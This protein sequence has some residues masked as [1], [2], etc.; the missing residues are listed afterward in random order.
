M[1]NFTKVHGLQLAQNSYVKNFGVETVDVDPSISTTGKVWFNT[2]DKKFKCTTLDSD[3]STIIVKSFATLDE[4]SDAINNLNTAIEQSAISVADEGGVISSGVTKFNFVGANVQAMSDDGKEVTVYMPPP[5]FTSHWNTNDGTVATNVISD[6]STVSRLISSPTSEGT[7]FKIGN[8]TAGTAHSTVT[9]STLTYTSPSLIC[10][11]NLTSSF[12]ATIYDADGTTILAQNTVSTITGD[13]TTSVQGI[14]ITIGGWTTQYN[15][16]KASVSVVY[17]IATIL[18]SGG[19]FSIK[20]VHNSSVAY[21]KS[22]NDLFYD[23]STT[24]PS[25]TSISISPSA[26]NTTK[27]LSGV[28]YYDKTDTF[29]IGMAGINNINSLTYPSTFIQVES[30]NYYGI[31]DFGVTGADL[32][33]WTTAYNNTGA[34]YS[35]I[36]AISRS[37]F[38]AIA[39]TRIDAYP[40]D[41]SS[42]KVYSGY[43]SILIDTYTSSST[44]LNE[45]FVDEGQRLNS[46]WSSWSSTSSLSSSDLMV[47]NGTLRRQYGDWTT[48][49][50]ANAVNYSGTNTQVQYFYRSYKAANVAHSNGIFNITGCTQ[51]DLDAGNVKIWIS[52]DG[53]AWYLCNSLYAGGTLSDG[54]GCRINKDS[55]P[56]PQLEFT[57]GTGGSTSVSTGP[58]GWGI[59]VKVEMP[60]GSAVQ[61][62]NL[63][64]TNW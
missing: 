61:L 18:P 60:S 50:P 7:P 54:S 35:G 14:T 45:D 56:L 26:L 58:T 1:S 46:D 27:Y 55:K 31:T 38:R 53:T 57:L 48:Y 2:V 5:S 39:S 8:W 37:N 6:V 20:M 52:L 51:A 11:D 36:K 63:D 28:R 34:T 29:A 13:S 24:D 62:T 10:F 12:T 32:G 19:R 33:S 22:Q 64:I 59:Y 21:T 42:A 15:K 23:N 47:V 30:N 49:L 44:L 3:G 16:Y 43:S 25:I 4:L 17:N 9:A 40:I 41:K